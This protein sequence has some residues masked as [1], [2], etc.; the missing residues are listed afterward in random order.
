MTDFQTIPGDFIQRQTP[1][2]NIL[3]LHRE[4]ADPLT[5][6]LQ[7]PPEPLETISTGKG[8]TRFHKL[9]GIEVAVKEYYHGG[10]LAPLIRDYYFGPPHRALEE[11][12]LLAIGQERGLPL[13]TPLGCA[14]MPIFGPLFCYRLITRREAGAR[15]LLQCLRGG[16]SDL[17]ESCAAALRLLHD[18]GIWHSDLNLA[19]FILGERGVII[20]DLDR[21]KQFAQLTARQRENNLKRLA[22]S[23]SKQGMDQH[24][25]MAR[26]RRFYESVGP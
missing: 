18:G 6:L 13:L 5:E 26:F 3:I 8:A 1:D 12:R 20:C 24:F 16:A 25:F 22:R 11:L 21:G 19:N 17:E 10:L 15:N 9:A 14:I 23:T 4:L 7:N 2:G